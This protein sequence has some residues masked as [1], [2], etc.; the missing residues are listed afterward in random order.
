MQLAVQFAQDFAP[1]CASPI[2]PL[3]LLPPTPPVLSHPSRDAGAACGGGPGHARAD[4]HLLLLPHPAGALGEHD[5][6]RRAGG[7]GC[8]G[9][10][11]RRGI[12]ADAA[13]GAWAGWQDS[14]MHGTTLACCRCPC[15]LNRCPG[16]LGSCWQRR[17][18]K[19][20]RPA[21]RGRG[22]PAPMQHW[23]SQRIANCSAVGLQPGLDKRWIPPRPARA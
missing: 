22:G 16:V 10:L 19:R 1:P 8:V 3:P 2:T 13:V 15:S 12:H 23:P 21:A 4:H 17:G 9:G 5:L 14:S 7:A 11:R 18:C 6:A 20:D